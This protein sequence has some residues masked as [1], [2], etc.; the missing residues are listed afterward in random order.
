[1]LS[2]VE[3]SRV[4]ERVSGHHQL[5]ETRQTDVAFAVRICQVQAIK[6]EAR[7]GGCVVAAAAGQV[8]RGAFRHSQQLT[9]QEP[10]GLFVSG[11]GFGPQR[12]K[13]MK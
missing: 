7:K 13:T 11:F 1:M 8:V 4:D 2:R 10:A 6:I 12:D 9:L 5:E 3:S